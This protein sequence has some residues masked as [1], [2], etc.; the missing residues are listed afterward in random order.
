MGA[1]RNR[2]A[3]MRILRCVNSKIVWIW[4]QNTH[5]WSDQSMNQVLIVLPHHVRIDGCMC[6]LR[7]SKNGDVVSKPWRIQS[8][9]AHVK[10]GCRGLRCDH[11]YRH[12]R[13][14]EDSERWLYPR[15][16]ARRAARGIMQSERTAEE[17]VG[18]LSEESVVMNPENSEVH[19]SFLTI[20][21]IQK[22]ARAP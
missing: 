22:S 15:P 20:H 19:T 9:F 1:I 6:G 10:E 13:C 12:E 11:P 7:E 3:L 17:L 14:Q 2:V 18:W 21:K 8:N 16:L 4:R 5:G